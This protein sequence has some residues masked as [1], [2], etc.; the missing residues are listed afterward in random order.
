MRRHKALITTAAVIAVALSALTIVLVN[1]RQSLASER[2]SRASRLEAQVEAIRSGLP[3]S[4]VS[5]RRFL[6]RR[7]WPDATVGK[8]SEAARR[9]TPAFHLT[10][11]TP[12]PERS[13]AL[14]SRSSSVFARL[15]AIDPTIAVPLHVVIEES[16][17]LTFVSPLV[18]R[19]VKTR[20]DAMITL[21]VLRRAEV[22]TSGSV[23]TSTQPPEVTS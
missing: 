7:L 5:D 3:R 15:F 9:L 8:V 21:T 4:L 19:V 22:A 2:N 12:D 13:S 18:I 17:H 11:S 10:W 20:A 16:S 23:T 1:G 6:E 14:L